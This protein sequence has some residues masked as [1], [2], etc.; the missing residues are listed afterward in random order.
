MTADAKHIGA[1]LNAQF[2]GPQDAGLMVFVHPN[3]MDSSSWLYQTAHFGTWYRCVAVDLPGYGRSP[4]A[5][6]GVT[7]PEIAAACWE[8]AD[9]ASGRTPAVLVGCSVGGNVVHHMY[10]QR[11]GQTAA[12]VVSGY[13]W[14]EVK[15]FTAH[16]IAAYTERG[17]DYRYDYALECFGAE[18]RQTRLAEWLARMFAERNDTADLASILN[19]FHALAEPDP[20]WL[21]RQLSAPV[22]VLSGSEDF[23]HPAAKALH[24]RLPRSEFVVLD[25]AGHACQLEQ[26]WRFDAEMIRF[27]R[28]NGLHPEP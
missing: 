27:L 12:L 20:D 18:F 5:A 2:C 21:H 19:V 25:G 7:M 23:T 10:H 17:L 3:P 6:Q 24:E 9:R 14:R 4:M 15:D 11:P 13:G 8:A 26:P 1:P 22:L 28:A 16:R